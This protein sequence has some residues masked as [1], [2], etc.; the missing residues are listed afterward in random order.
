MAVTLQDLRDV[1]YDILREE[2]DVSAYPLTLVDI[3]LNSA[4]QKICFWR[5]VN[6]LTKE[7]A[8]KGI[9]S[10]LNTEKFYSS[11]GSTSTTAVLATTDVTI[12]VN[13]ASSFP[14]AGSLYMDGNIIA[15]TGTTA[16]TFTW[17]TGILFAHASGTAVYP[18]YA[19]PSD[20][21][22]VTNVIYNARYKLDAQVYDDVYENTKSFKGTDYRRNTTRWP[23]SEPYRSKPFY[24]IKDNSSLLVYNLNDTGL[25]IQMRYEKQATEMTTGTDTATI[26]NDLYAKTTIPYLA[27]GEMLY[28]RWEEARAADILNFA[29]G[30]VR[31]MYG[32]YN[33]SSY[34]KISW[35]QYKMGKGKLNL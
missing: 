15:Y 21:A 26:S 9:L 30:Q 16:T 7:E 25:S 24:S 4:Q 32:Y 8:R 10:F 6:P 12:T 19:L 14:S 18:V 34:E 35:V 11:V 2:E 29:I 22:S 17:V 33:D 28:N 1:F 23:F 20:F 27:V 13:D 3:F 31:E 5:V